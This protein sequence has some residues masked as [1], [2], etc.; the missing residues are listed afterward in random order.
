M[1]ANGVVVADEQE[2]LGNKRTNRTAAAD[3]PMQVTQCLHVTIRQG[4]KVLYRFDLAPEESF[5]L[6]SKAATNKRKLAPTYQI[7]A[8][9]VNH[10]DVKAVGVKPKPGERECTKILAVQVVHKAPAGS[11]QF[12][13]AQLDAAHK[14]T[15]LSIGQVN[16]HH[17]QHS[18]LQI[19]NVVVTFEK[20]W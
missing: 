5:T 15:S 7:P 18:K 11:T 10:C 8:G 9:E 2:N 12:G 1:D 4:D 17:P 6:S 19:G 3:K 16:K 14:K 13:D 20:L